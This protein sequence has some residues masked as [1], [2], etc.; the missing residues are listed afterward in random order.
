MRKRKNTR[1]TLQKGK[2]GEKKENCKK[3]G[4]DNPTLEDAPQKKK[5]KTAKKENYGYTEG[6]KKKI[7]SP[8]KKEKSEKSKKVKKI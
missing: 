2:I 8:K 1:L 7:K 4:N 5:L 3:E 6:K